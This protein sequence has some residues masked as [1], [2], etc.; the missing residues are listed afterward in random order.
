M[1]LHSSFKL[2]TYSFVGCSVNSVR[3]SNTLVVGSTR[4]GSESDSSES[5]FEDHVAK[6]V[7]TGGD[8]VREGSRGRRKL[9]E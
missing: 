7:K 4:E 8:Q 1:C 3:A 6:K 5:K 2:Y 9:S